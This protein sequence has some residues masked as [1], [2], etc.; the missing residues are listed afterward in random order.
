M[1]N[2]H[3]LFWTMNTRFKKY[4][5]NLLF[6]NGLVHEFGHFMPCESGEGVSAVYGLDIAFKKRP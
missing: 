6:P 5:L 4:L 3:E 1:G 2:L